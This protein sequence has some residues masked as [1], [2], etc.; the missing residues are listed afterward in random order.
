MQIQA[1][2]IWRLRDGQTVGVL[3]PPYADAARQPAL[4]ELLC[5]VAVA[6]KGPGQ[7]SLGFGDAAGTG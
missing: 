3:A 6:V 1:A 2:T 4:D 7:D 5:A